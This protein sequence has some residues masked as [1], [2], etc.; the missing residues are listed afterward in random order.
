[1]AIRPLDMQVLVTRSA[2]VVKAN[3]ALGIRPDVKQEEFSQLLQKRTEVSFTQV[4]STEK[5]EQKFINK[6]GKGYGSGTSSRNK[7]DKSSKSNKQES[8]KNVNLYDSNY[9]FTV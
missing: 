5:S 2:D 4:Q 6:D 9:D 7:K 3:N 1:M 8:N